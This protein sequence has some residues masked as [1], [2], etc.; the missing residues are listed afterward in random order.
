[1]LV[2]CWDR[3]GIGVGEENGG[4]MFLCSSLMDRLISV[5]S[6]DLDNPAPQ[7]IIK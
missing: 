4:K 6:Y 5:I 1:V 2:P 7:I 3:R